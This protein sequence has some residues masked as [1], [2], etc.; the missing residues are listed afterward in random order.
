MKS[1]KPGDLYISKLDPGVYPWVLKPGFPRERSVVLVVKFD[2]HINKVYF[3][4]EE[5]RVSLNIWDFSTL[6]EKLELE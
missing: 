2:N 4:L 6:F 3:I 5:K 1:A